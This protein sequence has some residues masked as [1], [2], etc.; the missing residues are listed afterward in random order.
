MVGSLCGAID[1]LLHRM[2][3]KATTETSMK[4]SSDFVVETSST[5]DEFSECSVNEPSSICSDRSTDTADC[6]DLVGSM[7]RTHAEEPQLEDNVAQAPSHNYSSTMTRTQCIERSM[8]SLYPNESRGESTIAEPDDAMQR[9]FIQGISGEAQHDGYVEDAAAADVSFQKTASVDRERAAS[10]LGVVDVFRTPNQLDEE[11]KEFDIALHT[12]GVV[13]VSRGVR[14]GISFHEWIDRSPFWVGE[15]THT[16]DD[17][18]ESVDSGIS[19]PPLSRAI[20]NDFG[21]VFHIC[22]HYKPLSPKNARRYLD[23]GDGSL[24]S[25]GVQRKIGRRISL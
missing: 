2:Q 21:C 20:A 5:Q 8:A 14:E 9:C 25:R 3:P 6:E 17:D 12:A 4:C 1:A 13:D 18:E 11:G 19:G 7:P 23:F 10:S 24:G 22:K 15:D 16:R